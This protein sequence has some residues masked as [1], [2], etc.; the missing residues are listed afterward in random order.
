[1]QRGRKKKPDPRRPVNTVVGECSNYSGESLFTVQLAP[2]VESV[3]A[4]HTAAPSKINTAMR[5]KGGAEVDFQV[6][7][8]ATCD[9]LKLSAIKGTKYECHHANQSSPQDV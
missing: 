4:V 2:E 1:M 8:G 7:T 6:D 9:V 3:H 5:I